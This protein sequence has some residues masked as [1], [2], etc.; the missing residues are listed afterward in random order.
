MTKTECLGK[1]VKKIIQAGASLAIT[2]PKAYLEAHGL[3][4][5]D[6]VEVYFNS[7]IHIEPLDLNQVKAKLG[8]T[9][10]REDK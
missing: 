7:V 3:K 6:F 1:D 2:L 8:K 10:E 9:T 5:G 4:Q